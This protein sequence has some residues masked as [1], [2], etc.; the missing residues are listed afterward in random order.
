MKASRIEK[1]IEIS[2]LNVRNE[3]IRCLQISI[4]SEGIYFSS[5]ENHFGLYDKHHSIIMFMKNETWKEFLRKFLLMSG[6]MSISDSIESLS[7]T[8]DKIILRTICET[9]TQ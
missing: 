2:T 3:L 9:K 6:D 1:I 4:P 8:N 5:T 7:L